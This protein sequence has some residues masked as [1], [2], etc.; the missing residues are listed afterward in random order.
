MYILYLFANFW[1][2]LKILKIESDYTALARIKKGEELL[3]FISTLEGR[4]NRII[5]RYKQRIIG[6]AII[7][8]SSTP[9]RPITMFEFF[10][11]YK[12]DN[13][14]IKVYFD[15]LRKTIPKWS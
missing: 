15:D 13:S 8:M 3:I 5:D 2:R 12:E 10:Q 1:S 9:L 4:R 14:P 11:L 7:D 6:E